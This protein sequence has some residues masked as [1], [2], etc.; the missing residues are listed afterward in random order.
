MDTYTKVI[1]VCIHT[2]IKKTITKNNNK[3][4]IKINYYRNNTNSIYK[5]SK[6]EYHKIIDRKYY[7]V[8]NNKEVYACN[9][10][11]NKTKIAKENNNNNNNNNF[12]KLLI[13][14]YQN[15]KNNKMDTIH[16][17][18]IEIKNNYKSNLSLT[19]WYMI[20]NHETKNI[21]LWQECQIDQIYKTKTWH[22]HQIL[23]SKV[24]FYTN[25]NPI[26]ITKN[27][28]IEYKI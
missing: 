5:S 7:N 4:F 22:N 1:K 27:I 2:V 26:Q 25:D 6:K 8:N 11:I 24:K 12:K 16:K 20:Y 17:H 3:V 10:D 19:K 28:D 13:K 15:I 21:I 18:N 14:K 23:K 9:I